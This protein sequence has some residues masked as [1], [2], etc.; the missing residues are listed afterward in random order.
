MIINEA[1]KNFW[2]YAGDGAGVGAGVGAIV[3]AGVGAIV[4]AGVGAGDG[5]G[6]GAGVG[7]GKAAKSAASCRR[8]EF[9][10]RSDVNG[11]PGGDGP[12][13]SNDVKIDVACRDAIV[14]QPHADAPRLNSKAAHAV[15]WTRAVAIDVKRK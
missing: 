6:V 13:L 9:C 4:G 2:S 15:G 5:A 12:V 7:T 1:Q 14:A 11:D 8:K 3:G 10:S